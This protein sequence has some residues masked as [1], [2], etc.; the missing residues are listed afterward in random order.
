MPPLVIASASGLCNR[1]RVL[2]SYRQIAQ[3]AGRELVMYW[4]VN[5]YCPGRFLD[6]FCP[7]PG[8]TFVAN[9]PAKIHYFG[10]GRHPA[11]KLGRAEY[12]ELSARDFIQARVAALSEQ[13]YNAMHL[14]RTDHTRLAV[15]KNRFTSDKEFHNFAAQS[16]RRVYLACDDAG[17]QRMFLT[18]Y[19]DKIFV[20][21]AISPTRRI[22]QTSLQHAVVDL[23][24]CARSQQF[25]GS[26]YSSFSGLIRT[27][28]P[29]S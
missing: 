8:V 16:P 14:R 12:S 7:L 19:P 18:R 26:G 15:R 6:V 9:R 3:A 1:L 4:P 23:L 24:T 27:L 2:F 11:V 25:L 20:H 21:T 28:R 5:P 13:P 29:I 17:M 10:G 22:R